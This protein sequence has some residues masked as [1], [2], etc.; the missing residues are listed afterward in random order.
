MKLTPLKIAGALT[1]ATVVATQIAPMLP[2]PYSAIVLAAL[3]LVSLV[4]GLLAPQPHK[5]PLVKPAIDVSARKSAK[6]PTMPPLPLLLALLA[7]GGC[8]GAANGS[9]TE[10]ARSVTLAAFDCVDSASEA[11]SVRDGLL[12]CAP[13]ALRVVSTLCAAGVIP[14]GAFCDEVGTLVQ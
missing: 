4:A 13:P 3:P 10:D 1:G 9:A 12:G 14:P 5:P 11:P 6:F 2:P 8:G 7:L